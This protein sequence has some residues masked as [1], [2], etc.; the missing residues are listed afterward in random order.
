MLK[1]ENVTMLQ[2]SWRAVFCE[3]EREGDDCIMTISDH[4]QTFLVYLTY[5]LLVRYSYAVCIICLTV[6]KTETILV[7]LGSPFTDVL[8]ACFNLYFRTSSCKSG[9]YFNLK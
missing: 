2:Y 1:R 9:D 5:E 8:F 3:D 7:F 4:L 6:L